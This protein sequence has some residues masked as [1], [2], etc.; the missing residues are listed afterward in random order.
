[1]IDVEKLKAQTDLRQIVE[2]DLGRPRFRGRDYAA[3]KCPLHHEHKGYSL[4]VYAERWQCFGKCHAG[5]DAIAWVQ[6]YHQLTFQEACERLAM[7]DLP[8]TEALSRKQRPPEPL[9]QP[10]DV[11]WQ[12]KARSIIDD[13]RDR[14][15]SAEGQ[16]ALG[17]LVW[18]RG[19]SEEIIR[20]AQL[21][22]LPGAPTAWREI[23]GLNVPC[24]ILIPWVVDDVV[25][26]IK[27]RRAAGEQRYQQ[28]SGGNIR[29][30]LYLVEHILPGTPLV[31]T[32]GEF[33]ALIAFRS[34]ETSCGQPR[35]AAPA[36]RASTAAGMGRCWA[37]RASSS[38][39]MLML[40]AQE[41]R[42]SFRR[43]LVLLAWYR[44]RR[45][46]I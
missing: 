30:C 27:V 37:S 44:C 7:G 8:R 32:E 35:L 19:L 42:H 28:V 5:G 9:A 3:F 29:G 33:D 12:A 39:W 13:A 11:E 23:D 43:S 31:I 40:L 46:R 4:V 14:L 34:V 41:R 6:H 18:E 36:M 22:Y 38:V 21:G 26:G 24:G 2:R 25:W 1:M 16:R 17:Y 45:A 15:W 20:L 10:P